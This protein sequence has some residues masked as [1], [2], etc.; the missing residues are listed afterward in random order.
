MGSS[1]LNIIPEFKGKRTLKILLRTSHLLAIS[2]VFGAVLFAS[3]H[4]WLHTFWLAAILTGIGLML[5]DS[6]SN[7]LWFVQIRGILILLKLALLIALPSIPDYAMAI[8]VIAMIISG[9]ISHAPSQWRYYSI[10]HRK[11]V[12]SIK[13]S[14][15]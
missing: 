3:D 9:V 6:L 5:L 10:W 4:P 14:K 12:K 2:T 13:D 8:L 7:L 15:G 1:K 11:V